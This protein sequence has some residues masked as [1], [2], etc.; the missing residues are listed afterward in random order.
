MNSNIDHMISIAKRVLS[1]EI[2]LIEAA[3]EFEEIKDYFI[4]QA[5]D[6]LQFDD[7]S[8]FLDI[9]F[10]AADLP[11]GEDARRNWDKDELAKKDIEI[12]KVEEKYKGAVFAACHRILA[13]LVSKS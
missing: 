1:G 5:P 11:V 8:V 12:R 10:E 4:L 13:R 7:F 3:R 9:K 6:S 2:G